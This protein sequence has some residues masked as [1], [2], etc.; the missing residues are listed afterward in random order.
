MKTWQFL[1]TARRMA[2]ASLIALSWPLQAA[3]PW[4]WLDDS[5]RQVFSDMPPPASV[6]NNRIIRQPAPPS[7]PSARNP[8]GSPDQ[9]SGAESSRAAPATPQVPAQSGNTVLVENEEQLRAV[10][11]RNAEIRADNCR[12]A[13]EALAT[14][15]RPG[16]LATLNE[17]GQRVN[18]TDG[19]RRAE[20]ERAQQMIRENCSP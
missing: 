11:R 2:L 13:Q 9:A 20:V 18:M 15:Q 12:R 7:A 3:T 19:M 1:A 16:R 5:G 17:A 14:L 6:P 8:I 10:E 4:V